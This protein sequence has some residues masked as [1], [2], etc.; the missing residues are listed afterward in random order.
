MEY[1]VNLYCYYLVYLI[2]NFSNLVNT[3]FN[4]QYFTYL[5]DLDEL[6]KNVIEVYNKY[7]SFV[8]YE[9]YLLLVLEVNL[10]LVWDTYLLYDSLVNEEIV[11]N[12]LMVNFYVY[13]LKE[14]V[15]DIEDF[16][17][18]FV[19]YFSFYWINLK[20]YLWNLF[21]L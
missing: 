2:V 4:L 10:V 19:C 14:Y 16:V 21:D 12:D 6:V 3:Y 8:L 7:H 20:N 1:K 9:D 18:L 11:V 17:I 5:Y 15:S 13:Y